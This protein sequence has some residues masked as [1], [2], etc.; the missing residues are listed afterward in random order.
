MTQT[1]AKEQQQCHL[2]DQNKQSQLC[3]NSQNQYWR[4]WSYTTGSALSNSSTLIN[5]LG[6]DWIYLSSS[7]EPCCSK[8]LKSRRP[9]HNQSSIVRGLL[10]LWHSRPT[11]T[12]VKG[13]VSS[14]SEDLGGDVSTWLETWLGQRQH[15][16]SSCRFFSSMCVRSEQHGRSLVHSSL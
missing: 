7:V 6:S 3:M 9:T 14:Q 13:V 10:F 15:E 16:A 11:W 2:F 5:Y 8:R 12:N 4:Q 1:H